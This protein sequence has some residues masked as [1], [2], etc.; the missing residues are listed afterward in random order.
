MVQT[1]AGTSAFGGRGDVG[2]R[3]VLTDDSDAE[4]AAVRRVWPAACRLLC[5]FQLGHATWRWLRQPS[6]AVENYMRQERMRQVMSLVLSG[7]PET[8]DRR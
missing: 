5:T 8:L 1:L 4:G 2:P 6:N 7:S 3:H